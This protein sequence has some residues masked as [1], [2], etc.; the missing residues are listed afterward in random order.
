MT[1]EHIAILALGL[2]LL[3]MVWSGGQTLGTMQTT[4]ETLTKETALLR[5]DLAGINSHLIAWVSNHQD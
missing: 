4:I 5:A 2:S 3:G 1:K